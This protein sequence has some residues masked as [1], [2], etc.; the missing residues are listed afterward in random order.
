MTPMLQA[1][2]VRVRLGLRD[3]LEAVDLRVGTGWTAL[4]GPTAPASPRCCVRWPACSRWRQDASRST[5]WT[6]M[7]RGRPSAH[8]SW[9]GWHSRAT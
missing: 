9:R 7:P 1:A 3:V 8:A 4:V 5:A 6:C 2:G